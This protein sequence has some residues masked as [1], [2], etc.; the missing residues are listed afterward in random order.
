MTGP[1]KRAFLGGLV[2][3]PVVGAATP[4]AD[5]LA[6]IADIRLD[7]TDEG[8]VVLVT[9]RGSFELVSIS[10][11]VSHVRIYAGSARAVTLP[12]KGSMQ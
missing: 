8:A 11:A 10:A 1:S 6:N 2:S 9:D 3:L 12:I 7:P 4:A 5:P